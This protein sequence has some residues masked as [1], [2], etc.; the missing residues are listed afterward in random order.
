MGDN[1]RRSRKTIT[2]GSNRGGN[3]CQNGFIVKRIIC[4]IS[5]LCMSGNNAADVKERG[6]KYDIL[7]EHT[8]VCKKTNP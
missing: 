5:H 8:K 2:G 4:I 7:S 6:N 3:S 1:M